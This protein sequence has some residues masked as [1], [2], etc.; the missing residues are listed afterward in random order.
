MENTTTH[1]TENHHDNVENEML[2]QAKKS[3]GYAIYQ[4]IFLLSYPILMV[5]AFTFVLIIGIFSWI[6][7]KI[8]P[9]KN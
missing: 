4:F 5:F 8:L 3:W 9:K 6:S 7:K 2:L 1:N